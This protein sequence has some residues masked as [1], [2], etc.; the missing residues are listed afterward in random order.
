[1]NEIAISVIAAACVFAGGVGGLLLSPLLP[2]HHLTTETRDT[3]RLGMGM[4]SILA[5]LVLGL[6]TASAKGTFDSADQQLRAYAADLILLDETLRDYGTAADPIRMMLRQYTG[7]AVH[8]TW[9]DEAPAQ[10]QPLENKQ[11]GELLDHV[12]QA[13]LTLSPTIDNERWL[14]TQALQIA[15]QL[16]HTRWSLL[17]SQ[18]GAINPVLLGIMVA[19]IFIIF[20]SFGLYAPRNTTVVAAFFLCAMAIGASIFVI[21]EM[22]TPFNGAIM[23][24]GVPMKNALAHLSQ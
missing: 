9:P 17:V 24:S 3:V 21:L 8:T 23:I 1:M 18:E 22:D 13:T 2:M 12:M 5:S 16:I 14:R 4:I 6:L 11:A 15:A 19:W 10:A 20:A 7:E